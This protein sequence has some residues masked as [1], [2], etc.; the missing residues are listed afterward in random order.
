[1]LEVG[2]KKEGVAELGKFDK[3]QKS[4]EKISESIMNT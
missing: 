3:L 2:K 1:M 4:T